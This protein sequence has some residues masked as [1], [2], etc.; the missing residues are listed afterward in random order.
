MSDPLV[1]VC[2]PCYNNALTIAQTLHSIVSQSYPNLLIKVF[3]NASS[4]ATREVVQRFID[5]DPRIQLFRRESTVSGED[6]F[7]TCIA[8]AEGE[9]AAIFHS[10]D[11][12]E[13]SI[14][15]AQINFL[16]R[17]P[18]AVAVSTHAGL[19]DENGTATGLRM[20]PPELADQQES[21]LDRFTLINLCFKYGNFVTCPSVLFRTAI[22]KN[23][24][25]LFN[26]QA[27]KSSADL[28]V[29]FRLTEQGT[30]GFINLPLIR[31][32]VSAVSFSFNLARARIDDH[33]YFLVL[34]DAIEN[35]GFSAQQS[36]QLVRYRRFLL[37]KDRANTNLN[38]VILGH[39][40]FQPVALLRNAGLIFESRFHAK[41]FV[42]A[43][44]SRLLTLLPQSNWLAGLVKRVKF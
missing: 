19:I 3:D 42:L 32:R 7:N 1:C 4:D 37:M 44:F 14:I 11:V 9:F 41:F 10:D 5:E 36:T 34:D 20:V 15:A 8:E 2:I 26:G 13:S 18:D 28:N 30:F 35:G 22:L 43:L 38:R 31:Y 21:E 39:R 27:F 12:Y 25:Q 23:H 29:W 16:M 24:I 40:D 33:D 6:N 17:H